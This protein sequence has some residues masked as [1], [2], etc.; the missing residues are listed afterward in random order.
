MDKQIRI[1]DGK[2][3]N[4]KEIVHSFIFWDN[5]WLMTSLHWYSMLGAGWSWMIIFDGILQFLE[6]L[7]WCSRLGQGVAGDWGRKMPRRREWE[8]IQTG[9][10]KGKQSKLHQIL[11]VY[12]LKEWAVSPWRS[13]ASPWWQLSGG[14]V[15]SKKR[16][17]AQEREVKVSQ[18]QY[19]NTSPRISLSVEVKTL[20]YFCQHRR[21]IC[22]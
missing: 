20:E 7:Q 4:W 13:N 8:T 3:E 15:W 21:R 22:C 11:L 16:R 19:S 1:C 10:E 9:G 6:L 17:R 12:I 14:W 5:M 18:T 2:F